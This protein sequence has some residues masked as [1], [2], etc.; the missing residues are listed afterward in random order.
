MN[1]A[2]FDL[3][4]TLIKGDSDYEWGNFLVEH[5]YVDKKSYK[6]KNDY[7]FEQYKKGILCPKEFAKFSYEILKR[8]DYENLLIMRKIFFNEKIKP[9]VLPKAQALIKKHRDNKDIIAIVTSTNSFISK[10]SAEFFNI[11]HLLASEPEFINNKFTGN[12]VGEPCYQDGK[13]SKVKKWIKDNKF[14][15][16][17]D[18]YFYTDSHN[19]LK[20]L[21]FSTVP[22]AV[23][24]DNI[25]KKISVENNWDIISLR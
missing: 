1:I 12:L 11:N 18:I 24:P 2:L 7:F 16:S 8:Y 20:L 3:D 23:D 9:L 5:N 19:D 13:L 6:K 4:N 14:K 25:L 15:N 10:I 21:E 17:K 22:V